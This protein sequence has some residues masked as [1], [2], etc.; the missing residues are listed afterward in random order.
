M[1]S[2]S[3]IKDHL[4]RGPMPTQDCHGKWGQVQAIPYGNFEWSLVI[5]WTPYC[6]SKFLDGINV[7]APCCLKPFKV[8]VLD[9]REKCPGGMPG[10]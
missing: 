9:R 1:L 7:T 3:N 8:L 10:G 4:C 2:P 6:Q 5:L